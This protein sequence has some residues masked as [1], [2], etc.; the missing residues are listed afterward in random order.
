[1]TSEKQMARNFGSNFTTFQYNGQSIAYLEMIADSGQ[2]LV[3][4]QPQ[5]IQPLGSPH[6]VEIVTSR[7]LGGGTLTLTIRELWRQEVWQQLAGLAGSNSILDVVNTLAN[8]PN[9]VQCTKIITPPS[10]QRYGKV[11]HRCTIV[12][13]PDG[14]QVDITTLSQTKNITVAYTHTTPL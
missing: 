5:F 12:D 4:P 13:I 8:Q 6:P 14:E 3:V 9:Y 7:A 10:G 11:Y 1:M 2:Q